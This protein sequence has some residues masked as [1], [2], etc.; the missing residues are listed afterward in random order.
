M[1]GPP[2]GFLRQDDHRR[3]NHDNL[4]FHH[5]DDNNPHDNDPHDDD[6]ADHCPAGNNLPHCFTDDGPRAVTCA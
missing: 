4:D 2:G 3:D 5:H 6:I 1:D